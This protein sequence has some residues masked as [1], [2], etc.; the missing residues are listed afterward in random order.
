M[1]KLLLIAAACCCSY[2]IAHAQSAK[3]KIQISS[4]KGPTDFPVLIM[5]PIPGAIKLGKPQLITGDTGPLITEGMGWASPVAYDWNGDGKKDLLVGEFGSGLEHGHFV[6]SYIRVYQNTGEDAA[7]VFTNEF[8]YAWTRYDTLKGVSPMSIHTWCCMSFHPQLFDLD[9]DGHKDIITGQYEPG[10]VTWF[11][12]SGNGFN[13]GQKLEQAGSPAAK[14]T[15][16][17]PITDSNGLHYWIYSSVSFGDLDDDG[18]LD[19]IVGGPA[20]RVSYNIGTKTA[21]RFGPRQFLLDPNG[22][23]LK[24][25]DLPKNPNYW[26]TFMVAGTYDCVP[27]VMDWDHDGVLDMLVTAGYH[28]K[29]D[30][31]V[32][33][34]RGIKSGNGYRFQKAVP[35]FTTKDGVKGFPGSWL[36]VSVTD[37]NNDGIDDLLIGTSVATQDGNFEKELSWNWEHDMDIIKKNPGF[38]TKSRQREIKRALEEAEKFERTATKEELAK[39]KYRTKKATLQMYYGKLNHPRL[40]H[41]GYVY[42]MLGEKSK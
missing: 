39:D 9:A 18:D 37:W 1:K 33:F 5:T 20:L 7:P 4:A 8:E 36:R 38:D 11:R 6:G 32:Y 25:K 34:F 28:D 13:P 26:D 42:V 22:D 29:G 16:D 2:M 41:R 10:E 17:L 35:L 19:M 30:E 23:R 15:N 21:P 40:V 14:K 27:L 24:I 3:N 12:G 31:A